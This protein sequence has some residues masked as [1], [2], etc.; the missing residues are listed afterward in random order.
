[1]K[2]KII[3]SGLVGMALILGSCGSSNSVVSN[4]LIQKRKY[5]KGFF[6]KSNGQFKT[7]K[8]D[9]KEDSK[10]LAFEE[11]TDKKETVRSVVAPV[12]T[13]IKTV[14]AQTVVS[15]TTPKS[16]VASNDKVAVEKRTAKVNSIDV[17][18]NAAEQ[19]EV[20]KTLRSELKTMRKTEA[21]S[22][23]I[24]MD[25]FTVL[26][27]ILA[28]IIPPLAVLLYE[29]ASGRFWIDLLLALV[30]WGLAYWLLGPTIAFVGG[31]AAIIY[32]LLIVLE[33]I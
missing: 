9:T 31:L 16:L 5:N 20:R 18:Q 12:K 13:E 33:A 19:R 21:G 24:A 27:V 22:G 15:E 26:L 32:A 23:S 30:G 2:A 10:T 8:A 6:L 17:A 4:G 7:A 3:F 11:V 29:G 28:I 14:V 1:M 25:G